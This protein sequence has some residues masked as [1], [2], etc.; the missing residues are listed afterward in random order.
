[1]SSL[2]S[3]FAGELIDPEFQEFLA[4]PWAFKDKG[5]HEKR[6]PE[7]QLED[8]TW[9]DYGERLVSLQTNLKRHEEKYNDFK[10]QDII[11]GVQ[12]IGTVEVKVIREHSLSLCTVVFGVTMEKVQ[13]IKK[14]KKPDYFIFLHGDRANNLLHPIAIYQRQ[15]GDSAELLHAYE[16]SN[17]GL[18]GE[19]S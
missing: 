13:K 10:G 8:R 9:G 17:M 15:F 12:I 6:T 19:L 3:T 16:P 11:D 18:T 14:M 1:M 7:Q 2:T 4:R 5:T